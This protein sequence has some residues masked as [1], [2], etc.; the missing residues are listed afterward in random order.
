VFL[1][2]CSTNRRE[3][4]ALKRLLDERAGGMI[5]FFLSSDDN[6]I[7]HGTIWPAEVRAALDRMSL[8]LI[9]V[10][11]E[12]LKSGWTYFEAGYGL[13]KL[14]TAN[15]YCLPGTDKGALPSPFDILQNRNLHSGREVALLIQQVN[16]TLGGRMDEAVSKEAF[17]RIFK[18]P[19]IGRVESGPPFEQLAESLTVTTLGPHDSI[20]IFSRV[21]RERG[22]PVSK[23]DDVGW[24]PAEQRCST[25]LRITVQYPE[26][27]EL[28]SEFEITDEIRK[29]R[30]ARVIEYADDTWGPFKP[31]IHRFEDSAFRTLREIESQ[32]KR[33]REQNSRLERENAKLRLEP[34]ECEFKVSPINV[35]VPIQI[36]DLWITGLKSRQPISA[37]IKFHSEVA[38]E[39]QIEAISAKI[40]ASDV[41]LRDDGTLLWI[42]SII[43]TLDNAS[44]RV[45]LGTTD[46]EPRNLGDFR[47]P[48][49]VSRMFELNLVSLPTQRGS[50]RKR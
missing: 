32:N 42:N 44:R 3:L 35:S 50:K 10:S 36:I 6:S 21:C 49:L 19:S 16:E 14:K 22:F 39:R 9:F 13:H 2:H 4:L 29:E 40:H 37:E 38:L 41:S 43:V 25:G 30:K 28:L 34:R 1:S 46:M 15:I 23:L 33:V 11:S 12:A 18:K 20:D 27:N 17:D 45:K 48:E 26:I 47:I 8:M 24:P 7:A 31:R 5:E